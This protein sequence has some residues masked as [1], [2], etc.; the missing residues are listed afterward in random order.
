MV[1]LICLVCNYGSPEK[2]VDVVISRI[3]KDLVILFYYNYVKTEETK[4]LFILDNKKSGY[5]HPSL[6]AWKLSRLD[7]F[8]IPET[9]TS[10]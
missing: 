5:L 9:D 7:G 2:E 1:K 3:L 8:K 4:L 10:H 6:P